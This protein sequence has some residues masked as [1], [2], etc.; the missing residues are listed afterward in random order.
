MTTERWII[1]SELTADLPIYTRMNASDVLADPITPLGASL[2]W[3]PNILPG[4]AYGYV[5]GKTHTAAEMKHPASAGAFIYGHLYVNMT[6]AR[7]V[8]VRAGLGVATVDSM[9]FGG[10]PDA[11]PHEARPSDESPEISANMAEHTNWV[12]TATEFPEMDEEKEVAEH[13]RAT[14]PDLSRLSNWGLVAR[15]RSMMPLERYAWRGEVAGSS[16]GSVGPGVLASILPNADPSLVVRLVGSAGDV[17]S[18]APSFALWKLS[19][20]VRADAATT[21][22]FDQGVDHV[23][24]SLTELP[25]FAALLADFLHDFGSRGPNEWDLGSDSWETK[26]SLVLSLIDRLRHLDED[27]DPAL[28]SAEQQRIAHAALAEALAQLPEGDDA[29]RGL[30]DMALA[31]ARRFGNWRERGKTNCIKI[32]HEARV[33]LVELGRRLAAEG[34]L[35]SPHQ[36]FMA[37]D[38]ELDTLCLDPASLTQ[39]LAER[40][41]AWRGLFGLDLPTFIDARRPVPELSS[42]HRLSEGTLAPLTVGEVLQGVGASS[43]VVEGRARVV[44]TTDE[45]GDLEPGEILVAP[46]TDPSWTPLFMVAGGVVVDVGAM[47]SHAMIVSRELGIPC[48][49]SVPSASRRIPNGALISVDGSAGTVTVLA[50]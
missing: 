21:A 3:N 39:V 45:V 8:G 31:S 27:A 28:R 10:R 46:N 50:L 14:R 16:N 41:V 22:A 49:A 36:V 9:W 33:P 38:E 35:E 1:D 23:E 17:D 25:A 24:S 30:F 13:A 42:L 20:A 44:F 12:L 48:A 6:A 4:W 32:L 43:G 2:G 19:R 34:H 40:E 37:L 15:A 26:P 5:N 47:G 18:A 7:L 11:P 29:T